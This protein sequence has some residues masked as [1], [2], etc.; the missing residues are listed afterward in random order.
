MRVGESTHTITLDTYLQ[1]RRAYVRT[2]AVSERRALAVTQL[3]NR[4][5]LLLIEQLRQSTE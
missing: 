3:L 2:L 4:R 5:F 1:L